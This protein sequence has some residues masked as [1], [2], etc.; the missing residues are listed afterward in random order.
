MP[1]GRLGRE[2]LPIPDR[3]V[4]VIAFDARDNEA[5]FAA[6]EPLRP[7]VGAPNILVMMLD[8]V[9]FGAPSSF[10]GPCASPTA[11]RLA[12]NGLKSHALPHDGALFADPHGPVDRAQPPLGWA[13]AISPTS[14]RAR[15]GIAQYVR[16]LQQ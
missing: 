2:V 7:P 8:D 3:R 9:G 11:E 13:S 16:T 5:S 10:G 12:A 4:D 1:E 15:Q 6:A 14:P